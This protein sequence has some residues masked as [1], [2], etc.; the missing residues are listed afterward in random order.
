M[1]TASDG[2]IHIDTK[3]DDK[4]FKRDSEQLKRAVKS[5][6]SEGNRL[7]P[8]LSKAASGSTSAMTQ[9][10]DKMSSAQDH[11]QAIREQMEQLKNTHIETD[12]FTDQKKKIED[13]E[14]ALE[15]LLDKEEL[16][17]NRGVSQQSSVWKNLQADIDFTRRKLDTYKADMEALVESGGA[18]ISGD[19]TEE[20]RQL[21][22]T[23]RAVEQTVQSLGG[24]YAD[25]QAKQEEEAAAAQRAADEQKRAEQEAEEAAR[26]AA[27]TVGQ[28]V[29]AVKAHWQEMPRVSDMILSGFRRV[30]SGITTAA[31][32]VA[33]AIRHPIQSLDRL[34]G[35]VLQGVGSAI[36]WVGTT[37]L[38]AGKNLARLT[39]KGA[40]AGI[41]ALGKAAKTAAT[42]LT[43]MAGKA[44]LSGLRKIGQTA[45]DAAKS[46]L[47]IGKTS[48]KSG[49][50]LAGGLKTILKYGLG[51]RSLFVLVNKIRSAITEGFG[52]LAQESNSFNKAMSDMMSAASQFKNSIAAAFAPLVEAVAPMIT[53]VINKLT[54][55]TT[56]IG[57]F[58]AALTGAKT[59]SKAAAVQEDYAAS[60]DKSSASSKKAEKS[61]KDLKRQL[62]GFDELNIL[63]DSSSS[64]DETE[65]ITPKFEEVEIPDEILGW[66]DKLKEMFNSGELGTWLAQQINKFFQWL[67]DI[68]TNEALL[69]KI[70]DFVDKLCL[71][72]NNLIYNIDWDL[73][74]KTFADGIN[75]ITEILYRFLT[76]IDWEALGKGVGKGINSFVKN[77]HWD[78]VGKLLGAQI[79]A[80][81]KFLYG[82]V[83]EIDWPAIG[84]GIASALN[85][86]LDEVDFG[87]I[88]DTI[89]TGV[90]GIL[91]ALQSLSDNFS[92]EEF[93]QKI[94]D[95][96]SNIDWAGILA[97]A[98]ALVVSL[99]NN[100][101][102]TIQETA[103][104]FNGDAIGG[105][106]ADTINSLFLDI[107]WPGIGAFI[108]E[109]ISGIIDIFYTLFTSVQWAEI[110]AQF[111]ATIS[112]LMNGINWEELGATLGEG[113][114]G[115]LTFLYTAI[116]EYDWTGLVTNFYDFLTG[117]I[118]DVNWGELAST[119]SSSFAN[120]IGGIADGIQNVDWAQFTTDTYNAIKDYFTNINW[121]ELASSFASLWGSMLGAAVRIVI[122]L[123]SDIFTD[124]WAAIK[125]QFTENGKLTFDSFKDGLISA[126]KGIATWVKDNIFKPFID[127]F[128][129]AFGIASPST[130]ME[131]QGGFIISGLLNGIKGGWDA[132][133]TFFS[134]AIQG[135]MDFF[136]GE[137]GI[138]EKFKNIGHNIATGL[139]NGISGAWNT[140]KDGATGMASAALGAAKDFLGIESPS[141]VFR[142]EVG[143]MVG[144][145]MGEGIENAGGTIFNTIS[146]LTKGMQDRLNHGEYR[147]DGLIPDIQIDNTLSSFTDKVVDSFSA[148]LDKLQAIADRVTFTT[149]V[150]AGGIVPYSVAATG[151]QWSGS[152]TDVSN[153]DD[154]ASVIIQSVTNATV[155][156]VEA[157]DRK[158]MDVSL[159]MD[160]ITTGVV[161]GINRQTRIDGQSPLLI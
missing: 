40:I 114:K 106:I 115:A 19:Q 118:A 122:T 37:A 18:F 27:T 26:R 25:L 103:A 83:H 75:F 4:G 49:N 31:Y 156:I 62:A 104:A 154:L 70:L 60:L 46:I 147:L 89:S 76:G 87:M 79:M 153:N 43:R 139:A 158:K 90:Q 96:I 11:L 148:M 5:L 10:D 3:L 125:T 140:V 53:S 111:A 144:L 94:A 28:A 7:G 38:T 81:W 22:E 82:L 95:F 63:A 116:G 35:G 149:P 100:L 56:K 61:A 52:N 86:L 13:T 30:F 131:E 42:Y 127:G 85:G 160:D 97:Q 41:K 130:V 138:I 68:F 126:V 74:G 36:R 23:L 99:V 17:S 2:S 80:M 137:N 71:N 33:N 117:F 32:S 44:I 141:K 143:K 108:G 150:V 73:I 72:I 142:D 39:A 54:E 55:A 15:K 112:N 119:I 134:E 113:I 157:I 59:F 109:G 48:K 123:L 102:S 67:D 155:A 107:D 45:A 14:K 146:D 64:D 159:D 58:I 51:I 161:D 92:W 101:F 47:Q 8:L 128:A 91:A 16:L 88:A 12:D 84:E 133:T 136:T 65:A 152:Y 6:T 135:I 57:I 105:S 129:K 124:L 50:G 132:I 110:G 66:W 121:D 29:A 20:Y 78:R 120:V 21:E 98:T 34:V 24:D 151:Q 69:N 1:A 77:L 93:G 9:L 145:G